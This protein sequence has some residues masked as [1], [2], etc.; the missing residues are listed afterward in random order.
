[1]KIKQSVTK[2]K[3]VKYVKEAGEVAI[4]GIKQNKEH[5]A[6]ELADLVYHMLVLISAVGAKPED[7]YAKLRERRQ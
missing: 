6:E 5:L 1:M 2:L 3:A 7:L 4:A